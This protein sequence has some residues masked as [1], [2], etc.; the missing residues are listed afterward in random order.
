MIRVVIADD[1]AIV[2][3]G[4]EVILD[5]HH[6]IEVVGTASDGAE[7]VAVVNAT[8]PDVVV[9]D[10]QMPRVDGIQA[11]RL[12]TNNDERNDTRVLMLTTFG[13]DQLV[14]AALQAG[15]SGFLL[16][17]SGRHALVH[18][19]QCVAGG[20]ELV[21]PTI[22][23]RLV[24]ASVHGAAVTKEPPVL[25]HLGAR[26]IDVLRLV[27]KGM[28]NAEIADLLHVSETTV[29]SHVASLLRKLGQ[30]D[31]IQVVIWAYETGWI[32]P[33]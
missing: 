13:E 20:N 28:A 32:R 18:A 2:R 12:L 4:L 19:V 8:E 33:E 11:T 14:F 29:K 6:G 24:E 7:A 10:I 31:R 16:K 3:D 25:D 23:R 5:A 26:E 9:M 17:D 21:D 1:Q 22:T 15:A 30:R 27:V